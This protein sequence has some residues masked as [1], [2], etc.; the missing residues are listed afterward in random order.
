QQTPCRSQ[1]GP[2][3]SR[4]VH[5]PEDAKDTEDDG[6]KSLSNPAVPGRAY[7]VVLKCRHKSL[8]SD[9][10]PPGAGITDVATTSA[11]LFIG[12][13]PPCHQSIPLFMVVSCMHE[14]SWTGSFIS[15]FTAH[16]IQLMPHVC[17]VPDNKSSTYTAS[18]FPEFADVSPEL[19]AD[20]L[21][22]GHLANEGHDSHITCVS[23]KILRPFINDQTCSGITF[24]VLES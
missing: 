1:T 14:G 10:A 3:G 18:E 21:I 24:T 16:I 20:T 22:W 17:P 15:S 12:K 19:L 8:C 23:G 13:K 4:S 7:G 2:S 5:L 11:V 9:P 6:V